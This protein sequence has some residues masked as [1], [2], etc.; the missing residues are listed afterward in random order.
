MVYGSGVTLSD[1]LA[2][3]VTVS[4]L[5]I[6]GLFSILDHYITKPDL[7]QCRCP[8]DL[9]GCDRQ[10]I[11]SA[12]WVQNEF[13]LP[14]KLVLAENE[15]NGGADENK[16][17]MD[18]AY[19]QWIGLLF[20]ALAI[21][22]Y[23]PRAIWLW[24]STKCGFS[25]EI[26]LHAARKL[27]TER[28]LEY[29]EKDLKV[30]VKNIEMLV[31]APRQCT[32]YS[33]KLKFLK[34]LDLTLRFLLCKFTYI[35]F[36]VIQLLLVI[37]FGGTGFESLVNKITKGAVKNSE[38]KLPSM[39]ICRLK[40]SP[41]PEASYFCALPGNILHQI[42]FA[43]IFYWMIFVLICNS[44]SL[45]SW[46]LKCSTRAQRV[47]R[48]KSILTQM[49]ALHYNDIER[50]VLVR[51]VLDHMKVDGILIL[52]LIEYHTDYFTMCRV[53]NELWTSFNL[54]QLEPLRPINDIDDDV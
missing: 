43:F 7:I 8:R 34:G 4:L 21:M 46:I 38:A 6:F 3:Q 29:Y 35:C 37:K 19:F 32:V 39:L 11:N 54:R 15:T 27:Q 25:E 14:E 13:Y 45:L 17:Q 33:K 26:Y 22:G 49:D 40:M 10:F 20:I 36:M 18:R 44:L 30:L 41:D 53:V 51:F 2:S 42:L 12:C 1:K 23:I 50:K 52:R 31:M 28:D 5:V 48:M 9:Q 24:L 47:R 16:L